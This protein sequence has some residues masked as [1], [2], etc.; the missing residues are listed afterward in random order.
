MNGTWLNLHGDHNSSLTGFWGWVV[1][2][3]SLGCLTLW[4]PMDCS[5]PGS[6]IL[7][8]LPL[9][10]NSCPLSQGW[11]LTI[12]FSATSSPP[13][14]NLS[15]HQGFFPMVVFSNCLHQVAKSIGASAPV[16]INLQGGFPLGLTGLISLLS[17]ALSRVFSNT[18]VGGWGV[19]IKWKAKYFRAPDKLGLDSLLCC[20]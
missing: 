12:S 7:H 13:V 16:P 4:D 15:Q 9:C 17:N 3:Q 1:A 6:P 20:L 14:F 2:V 5:M 8:Y 10:S 19:R 18:T 11:Y